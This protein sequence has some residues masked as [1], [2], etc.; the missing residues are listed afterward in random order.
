MYCSHAE[1]LEREDEGNGPA[2]IHRS[3]FV[4]GMGGG[5]D[6]FILVLM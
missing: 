2:V 3:P 6:P 4:E 1:G 5:F